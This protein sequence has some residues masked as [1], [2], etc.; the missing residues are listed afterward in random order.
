VLV[1]NTIPTTF[2]EKRVPH[3]VIGGSVGMAERTV[4]PLTVILLNRGGR[5]YRSTVFQN[6]E[7]AGIASV[8][9]VEMSAETYDVESL[10]NRFPRV[11]FL[12]PL[13]RVSIGELINMAMAE[14]LSPRVLVLWNDQRLPSSGI[15]QRALDRFAENPSLCVVPSLTSQKLENVPVYMVPAFNG[16][17]LTVESLPGVRDQAPTAYAFDYTGIYDRER[18][19]SLG[20]YDPSITTPHWQ[21]LDLGFRSYLWGERIVVSTAFRLTYEG[22]IPSEDVTPDASY[23]SFFLKN[24][25]P[26]LGKKGIYLPTGAFFTLL[27]KGGLNFFEAIALFRCVKRWVSNN[28]ARFVAD[29]HAVAAAWELP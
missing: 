10:S 8:I 29:A 19:V 1:M 6:L 17:T 20:G 24:L 15:S 2:N 27:A 13:E 4:E 7:N 26:V 28:R 11:K 22:D 21:N 14:T 3:T 25:A 9:S 16:K 18:F 5:F 12:V 23:V